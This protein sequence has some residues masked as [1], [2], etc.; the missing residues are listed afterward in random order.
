M[1]LKEKQ[2]Q[3]WGIKRE[4]VVFCGIKTILSRWLKNTK[5]HIIPAH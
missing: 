1:A 5:Q 4:K 3:S 2:Q